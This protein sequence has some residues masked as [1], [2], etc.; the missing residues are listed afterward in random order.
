MNNKDRMSLTVD[1]KPPKGRSF[2][3]DDRWIGNLHDTYYEIL[4]C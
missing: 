2:V 1:N 3:I 4:Y